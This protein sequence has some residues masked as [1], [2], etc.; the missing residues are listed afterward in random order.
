M[1]E[2]FLPLSEQELRQA[3]ADILRRKASEACYW[4]EDFENK[5]ETA[6]TFK[7]KEIWIAEADMYRQFEAI[8]NEAADIALGIRKE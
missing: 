5:A 6:E 7:M 8:W 2:R 1:G 4:K 3:V